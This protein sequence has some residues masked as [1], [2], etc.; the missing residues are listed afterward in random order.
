MSTSGWALTAQ[1]IAEIRTT[2]ARNIRRARRRAGISQQELARASQLA[3]STVARLEAA[4]QDPR[5]STLVAISF[6]L[7]VPLAVLL[8]GLPEPECA[9]A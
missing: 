9:A 1:M 6:G 7:G 5:L 8:E 3:K 2:S 4:E